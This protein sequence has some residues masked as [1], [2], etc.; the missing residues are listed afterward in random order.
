MVLYN[1]G[2]YEEAIEDYDRAIKFAPFNVTPLADLYAKNLS[3][4]AW[5]GKGNALKALG[6]QSEMEAA[7]SKAKE[8]GYAG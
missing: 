3:A 5:T 8:L 4:T 1:M 7:Y 2:R 6:R